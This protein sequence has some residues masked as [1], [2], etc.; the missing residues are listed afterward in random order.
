MCVH[1]IHVAAQKLVILVWTPLLQRVATI[2]YTIRELRTKTKLTEL[3]T[4]ESIRVWHGQQSCV[5]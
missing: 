3:G 5:L 4:R 1:A 2:E